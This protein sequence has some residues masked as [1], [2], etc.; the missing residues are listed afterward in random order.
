MRGILSA[1]LGSIFV[2]VIGIWRL[3]R[4]LLLLLGRKSVIR[5]LDK[6]ERKESV[7]A[8]T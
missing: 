6:K 3:S 8:Y 4:R 5:K 2:A 1:D 7:I